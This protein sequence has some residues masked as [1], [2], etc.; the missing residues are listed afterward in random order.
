MDDRIHEMPPEVDGLAQAAAHAVNVQIC[1]MAL[2]AHGENPANGVSAVLSGALRGFCE[3]AWRNR[4]RSLDR[5]AM[6]AVLTKGLEHGM[7]MAEAGEKMGGAA[8]GHG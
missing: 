8:A 3:A 2:S 1:L 5:A 6:T 7:A 4:D